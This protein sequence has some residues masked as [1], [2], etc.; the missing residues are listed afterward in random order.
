MYPETDVLPVILSE[1]RWASTVKPTLLT[2]R[3]AKFMKQFGLDVGLARQIAFSERLPLFEEA[4][5]AGCQ[6]TLA[7]R[8][9]VA[10]LRELKREGIAVDKISDDSILTL[11]QAVER[12]DL[13]KEAV[14]AVLSAVAEGKSVE[15]AVQ[16]IAPPFSA[17]ELERMVRRILI[18]RE[19]FVR[20]KGKAALGP[21]MG[22]V[23]KEVRGRIDGKVVSEVLDREL[24]KMIDGAP[25]R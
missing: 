6:P 21:L 24:M 25:T 8:T 19:A 16:T 22:I 13:A 1:E 15:A 7:C 5:A 12:G 18:E 2:D 9:L 10:T 17:D 11:L 14:P 4:V 23:M 20:Q 3:A